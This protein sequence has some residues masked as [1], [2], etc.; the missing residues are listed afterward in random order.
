MY[1][2]KRIKY[3]LNAFQIKNS[4]PTFPLL[5]LNWKLEIYDI[6][7]SLIFIEFIKNL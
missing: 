6:Y 7:A 4:T 1:I 2:V 5:T 3:A